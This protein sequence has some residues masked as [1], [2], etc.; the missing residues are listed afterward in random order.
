MIFSEWL[1]AQEEVDRD[2]YELSCFTEEFSNFV[3]SLLFEAKTWGG[4]DDPES[5]IQK[6]GMQATQP[7]IKEN[8]GKL[9]D[10]A[11]IIR[12]NAILDARDK[13]PEK[14]RQELPAFMDMDE[15]EIRSK[16]SQA[17]KDFD[18][19][20]FPIAVKF[21]SN[22]APARA[23]GEPDLWDELA[24]KFF[25]STKKWLGKKTRNKEGGKYEWKPLPDDLIGYLK[26]VS[27]NLPGLWMREKSKSLSPSNWL[28]DRERK[29][30][31]PKVV[32]GGDRPGQLPT[33][34][35]GQRRGGISPESPEDVAGS[36][37]MGSSSSSYGDAGYAGPDVDLPGSRGREEIPGQ[38][39]IR[40]FNWDLLH[41]ALKDLAKQDD[42]DN[43]RDKNIEK[44]G[45]TKSMLTAMMWSLKFNLSMEG[46]GSSMRN[47][48]IANDYIRQAGEKSH[49]NWV[50]PGK[51]Q[52]IQITDDEFV[53]KAE[54][55]LIVKQLMEVIW[56]NKPDA[57]IIPSGT[58]RSWMSESRR[59]L[60]DW[61]LPY[62]DR[63]KKIV[64]SIDPET[65]EEPPGSIDY[66]HLSQEKGYDKDKH[67]N[68]KT[69]RFQPGAGELYWHTIGK[70]SP[71]EKK[72]M[73]DQTMDWE[74][75]EDLLTKKIIS[76]RQYDAYKRETKR[77]V[78][79]GLSL[80]G[81]I[82]NPAED[83]SG[84]LGGLAT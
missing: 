80:R 66:R 38:S 53:T 51:R 4:P 24:H 47:L 64:R 27:K 67:K 19:I 65:G 26:D 50:L 43:P 79:K 3:Y 18:D 16:A 29:M 33:Y 45:Y 37:I 60:R 71:D 57:P 36:E 55:D 40:D 78:A 7:W 56:N 11:K 12:Y 9:T 81:G 49:G 61:L 68:Y 39:D 69:S 21:T 25:L 72:S 14:K 22:K 1:I 75:L 10:A 63:E 23:L 58:L 17:N 84:V 52:Q 70:L 46:P 82:D 32:H 6:L 35:G 83:E 34:S 76:Q 44:Y 54:S 77:Q 2:W 20:F 73:S 62:E 8:R 28:V 41:K 42:K 74:H 15:E 59:W 48:G 13:L 30:V 31:R 5:L